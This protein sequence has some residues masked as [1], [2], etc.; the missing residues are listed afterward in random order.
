MGPRFLFAHG[1]GAGSHSEWMLAWY[2]RLQT[3]GDVHAFDY[4]YMA[5]GKKLPDRLPSLLS[6]HLQQLDRERL[7]HPDQPLFLAGKSMGGR[8][9]LHA[10]LERSVSGLICFGYPLFGAGK[11]RPCRDGVL[12]ELSAPVLFVQ[13]TRDKMCPLEDLA[14]VRRKM[15]APS[16]VHVVD[17]GD[18]SLSVRKR[19][20]L[21]QGDADA[22]ILEAITAFVLRHSEDSRAG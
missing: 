21:S 19:D 5:A 6:Q 1:A 9:G 4:G 15:Q 22:Q 10:S 13:G 7:K 18:H 14:D 20:A 17:G 12:L 2:E 3:I 11:K 8:V 16:Q